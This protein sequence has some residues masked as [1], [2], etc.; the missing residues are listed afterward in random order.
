[1]AV[2]ILLVDDHKMLRDG[3]RLRLQLERDFTIV[4]EATSAAE[5]QALVSRDPPDVVVMDVNLPDESGIAASRRIHAQWPAVKLVVVTSSL[6]PDVAN[7]ALLAGA[8]GFLRKEDA[9]DDL[10]R[11]I[12]TVLA[13]KVF[14]SSDAAT[15]VTAALREKKTQPEPVLTEQELA[16]L[17]GVA[18]GLGYKEIA[19]AMDVSVKTVETYRARLT[20]KLG[21]STRAELVRYA[22]RKG[23]VAP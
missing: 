12:R 2:R 1:M 19:A 4:G 20:R 7:G 3:L 13:G 9:S 10:V 15:A 6:D 23:L 14:L 11:A 18:Q 21:F 8:S 17:K 16:V 5:A 22:V